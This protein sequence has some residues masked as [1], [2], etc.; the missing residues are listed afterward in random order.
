MNKKSISWLASVFFSAQLASTPLWAKSP[1]GEKPT[2]SNQLQAFEQFK[3]ISPTIDTFAKE[4]NEISVV[5]ELNSKSHRELLK[6]MAQEVEKNNA[7]KSEEVRKLVTQYKPKGQFQ[8]KDEER[9]ALEIS[10]NNLPFFLRDSIKKI[11]T[12]KEAGK[13]KIKRQYNDRLKT[14]LSKQHEE[15]KA[16][17]NDLGGEV[18]DFILTNNSVA[19]KIPSYALEKLAAHKSVIKVSADN[20][21]APELDSQISSLG[22]SAFWADGEDGGVWDVGILDN[23]VEET[24]SALNS[25]TF[26][27]NYA[28]NGAHG[29]GI[30][31]MYGSTDATFRGLAYG[32]DKFLVDNAG[33]SSTSMAGADWMVS[34]ATD[35]PEVINYSWGNGSATGIAWGDMARFV[36]G[37]VHNHSVVWVKSAGNQGYSVNPTMTQPGENYNGITVA[38]MFDQN[39]D[40][41]ADDV[42]WASSS[43]GPT[44]DGRRKPDISAPGHNTSTCGLNNSFSILGGTSS[45]AP[46]VGATALLLQDSGHYYPISMK[47]TL[48]NTADSWEDNNT[49]TTAD[50]G[51]VTGKEWNRTYGWGYLDVWHAEFHKDDYFID[52]I[53]PNGTANDHKFYVGQGWV[54]DKATAVWERDVSYNDDDTPTA[55]SSLSDINMRLYDE[56]DH[57]LEDTD[58][59]ARDNV[60][61]VAVENS[62]VKVIKVY[63]WNSSVNERVALATEEGFSRAAPPRL[64]QVKSWGPVGFGN[65]YSVSTQVSNGGD[66]KAHNVNAS[67]SLPFGVSLIGSASKALSGIDAGD[68]QTATWLVSTSN[69]ALLNAI[70][71]TASSNSYGESYTH[72]TP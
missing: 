22:V 17:V 52:I 39:T 34:S 29:T 58:F 4:R 68:S 45:A 25:H 35:D 69:P 64:S 8:T 13:L 24:H 55:F 47:A 1:E 62:G 51:Q 6:T 38:N 15:F 53:T 42:I 30:A 60:H 10:D 61:Q 36:D 20:P 26:L 33:S 71:Y 48:I 59:S 43:R 5:V 40:S 16:F 54:G 18:N 50:D 57:S 9:A 46:K 19:V 72:T 65:L 56:Q 14:V 66:I 67:I 21:G 32:M 27:E 12:E 11:N 41:R 28:P 70:Q 44:A 37:V 3:K 49:Q 63:S 31:C 7:V 23:G 2:K